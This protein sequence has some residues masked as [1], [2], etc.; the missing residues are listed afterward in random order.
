MKVW[1]LDVLAEEGHGESQ[2]QRTL[3]TRD[4]KAMRSRP[5]NVQILNDKASLVTWY[6]SNFRSAFETGTSIVWDV[7]YS[8]EIGGNFDPRSDDA[9]YIT[10]WNR[11]ALGCEASVQYSGDSSP[12]LIITNIFN[13]DVVPAQP[14]SDL[15]QYVST[16]VYDIYELR[17]I[18][19][20]NKTYLEDAEWINEVWVLGR[21]GQSLRLYKSPKPYKA[22]LAMQTKMFTY[23]GAY[24]PTVEPTRPW[25]KGTN[26]IGWANARLAS[27]DAAGNWTA[28]ALLNPDQSYVNE[29]NGGFTRKYYVAISM[30]VVTS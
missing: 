26:A 25:F 5:R 17:S 9:I 2:D 14:L 29:G 21:N 19:I 30:A 8:D 13:G 20:L 3:Q 11:A 6:N 22:T 10:A 27:C 24:G 28:E 1:T 4:E 18:T 16:V 23:D 12:A 7:L 15:A